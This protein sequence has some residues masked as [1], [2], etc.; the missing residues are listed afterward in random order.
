MGKRA[1]HEADGAAAYRKRQKIT[2]EIPAG[3]DV[4]D[5]AQLRQLLSFDQDMRK[6]RH[7][8]QLWNLGLVT[9]LVI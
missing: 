3:E 8:M 1:T 9:T 4:V 5:S 6:A 2:H 7:G